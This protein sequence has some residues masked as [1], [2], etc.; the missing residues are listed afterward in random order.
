MLK[1][2]Y[3][4]PVILIILDCGAGITY[5]VNGNVKMFFY[6]LFAAGLTYC[7]TF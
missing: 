4:F 3:I 7:V 5:L 2:V 6:W 1:K